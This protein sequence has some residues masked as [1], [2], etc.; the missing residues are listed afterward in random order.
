MGCRV[1]FC[2][3]YQFV[4]AH[5]PTSSTPPKPQAKPLTQ[6]CCQ[7]DSTQKSPKKSIKLTLYLLSQLHFYFTQK[8]IVKPYC[9][10]CFSP[11]LF[12]QLVFTSL[13]HI[14][15]GTINTKKNLEPITT[16]PT[17]V[18]ELFHSLLTE[19]LAVYKPP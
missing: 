1:H 5:I 15:H 17:L 19:A 14:Y 16:K 8:H 18:R 10:S 12:S 9:H 11:S 6:A 13:F 7:K 3:F 4:V 2:V